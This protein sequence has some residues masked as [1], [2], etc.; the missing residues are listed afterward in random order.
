M[1][2]EVAAHLARAREG[3]DEERL[4]ATVR[5]ARVAARSAYLAAFHAAEALVIARTGKVAK[6]HAGVHAEFAR[7]TRDLPASDG[8]LRRILGR[9][10]AFKELA[11]YGT[12]PSRVVTDADAA[13][14]IADA[15]R[16]VDR[17]AELLA[18]PSPDD[19]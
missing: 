11:D 8:A 16:F 15:A 3:L 14:M 19:A 9:G 5:L 13:A 18:A 6:T 1:T 4:I 17:V 12:G 2:P 7:L 10:Y